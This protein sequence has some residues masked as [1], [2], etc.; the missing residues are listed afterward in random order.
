MALQDIQTIVFL[1]LENRSFDHALGYLS[2]AAAN[3]PLAVEGL[4]DDP[5]WR[6][7]HA[8]IHAGVS[9]PLHELAAGVQRIIDPPHDHAAIALQIGVRATMDG[10][11]DS[12][13]T[14]QPPP[15][16]PSVVMGHY[17]AAA[18]PMFDFLARNFAV[19]DHWF[20]AL[21]T[22]TQPNRLMAMGGASAILDNAAVFLPDQP[23]AYD[24]LTAQK[25]S[26]CAYQWGDFLPF[27]SLMPRLLPEIATSL[28]YDAVGGRG[29]FRRY[30]R[31]REQWLGPE[32]MPSVIF[33][34]P[35]YTDGPHAAP[36]DD[37]PPSGIAGGQAFVAD[38]Y[39]TLIANPARWANTML[40]VT[41]DEHGGFFDHVPPLRISAKAG[42]V[43]VAS[44]GLRVPAFVVSPRVAPG[45]P[46]TDPLDHTSFLQLLADRFTPGQG[47]SAEVTARQAQLGRLSTTLTQ[48]PAA[49]L[50]AP[51]A[52]PVMAHGAVASAGRADSPGAARTASAFDRVAMKLAA[53]HPDLLGGAGWTRLADYLSGRGLSTR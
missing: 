7:A 31:F 29:R 46:F 1:M 48:D 25:V 30:A 13:M 11:V 12:Y 2:M 19:C 36:N 5:A 6:N 47:Y 3:P 38:L 49:P 43:A 52:A 33:V 44:T 32:A 51:L 9:Y 28:A 23:L 53:D 27:F 14:R 50:A 8:N 4:R 40:I 18:V 15:P 21:P 37:H 20:A 41:Y 16:D 39:A 17:T 34:E 26:W 10:F 35:E 24:W 22:G 42:G 45:V